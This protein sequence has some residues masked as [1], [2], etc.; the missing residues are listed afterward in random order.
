MK[1]NLLENSF[2]ERLKSLVSGEER[3]PL[4]SLGID[5]TVPIASYGATHDKET[6]TITIVVHRRNGEAEEYHYK[7]KQVEIRIP[8]HVLPAKEESV[9]PDEEED[10]AEKVLADVKEFM[11]ENAIKLEERNKRLEQLR[12]DI[13]KDEI[14][15]IEF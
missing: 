7:I 10:K 4:S 8:I 3:I 5:R 6:E 12:Q 1:I 15:I 14:E 2:F 13:E 9:Q 11:T